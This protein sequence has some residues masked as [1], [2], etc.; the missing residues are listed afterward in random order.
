[1]VAE[2]HL[3]EPLI[4][5]ETPE[6][7]EKSNGDTWQDGTRTL[8]SEEDDGFDERAALMSPPQDEKSKMILEAK[9]QL[10]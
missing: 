1:M 10:G 2:K 5:G 7:N 6:K 8:H 4:P 9:A 3:T